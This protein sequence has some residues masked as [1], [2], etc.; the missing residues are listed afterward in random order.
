MHL[1]PKTRKLIADPKK[2]VAWVLYQLKLQGKNLASLAREAGVK[3]QQTA[4]AMYAPYP[5]MEKVVADALGLAPKDLFPERY[6]EDGLP[7]RQ[8]GR[9]PV[10]SGVQ[11][12]TRAARRNVHARAAA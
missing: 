12:T 1:D 5:R 7:N 9:P 10:K 4:K 11:N 8:L 3:K 2:R 6:N